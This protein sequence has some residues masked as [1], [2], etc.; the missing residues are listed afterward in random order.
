MNFEVGKKYHFHKNFTDYFVVVSIHRDQYLIDY[1]SK[2]TDSFI[3]SILTC[4]HNIKTAL[5]YV[6]TREVIHERWVYWIK[7]RSHGEIRAWTSTTEMYKESYERNYHPTWEF[8]KCEKITYIE[9]I[10]E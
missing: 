9:T 2:K 3:Q 1:F 6:K 10:E 5:P 4:K 7:N 8:L